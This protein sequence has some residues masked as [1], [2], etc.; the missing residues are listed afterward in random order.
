MAPPSP[1]QKDS[2]YIFPIHIYYVS[3][4][5]YETPTDI[6]LNDGA[7]KTQKSDIAELSPSLVADVIFEQPLVLNRDLSC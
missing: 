3:F 7:K 5:W 6:I 1:C 2:L 4:V